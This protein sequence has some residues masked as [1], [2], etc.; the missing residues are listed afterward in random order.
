ME[1]CDRLRDEDLVELGVAVDDQPGET[2]A[3]RIIR[4]A[5]KEYRWTRTSQACAKR[6]IGPSQRRKASSCDSQSS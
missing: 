3:V 6:T 4:Q 5:D 2:I 1:L